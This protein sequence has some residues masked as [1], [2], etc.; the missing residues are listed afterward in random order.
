MH[1]QKYL[2]FFYNFTNNI[3]SIIFYL[4]MWLK[5]TRVYFKF[6]WFTVTFTYTDADSGSTVAEPT[7]QVDLEFD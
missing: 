6:E 5:S 2:M 1:L 7:N 4:L 3:Y